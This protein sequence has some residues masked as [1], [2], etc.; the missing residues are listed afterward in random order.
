LQN[1]LVV[2]CCEQGKGGGHLSRCTTLVKD[3]RAA[4]KEA[5]LYLPGETNISALENLFNSAGFNKE[6]LDYKKSAEP[7]DLII[8]DRF[9]TPL[10]EIL[11]WKNLA[12]V[13]G[14]DEGGK[15]RDNFDFLIDMLI[16]EKLGNPRANIA[17]PALLFKNSTTNHTRTFGTHKHEPMRILVSFGQEDSA[18]LGIKVVQK[19]SKMNKNNDWEITLV[20]GELSN[21][22]E[23]ITMNNI[24][25]RDSIPNLAEHLGEY[26]LVITHYGL[27]A[28]EALFAGTYVLLAH[29]TPYHRK[30][31]NAA[32]FE[33]FTGKNFTQR[34]EQ[35]KK[36]QNLSSLC[37]CGSWLENKTLTDLINSFSPRVNR[38]CPVCGETSPNKS[39]ARFCDRTYRKCE[40]CGIIFM[41]RMNPPPI[42]YEK[43]YF[44]ESYKK[45]Y[46]KTYLEDFDNIKT[47]GKQRLKFINKNLTTENTEK[48][49]FSLLDIGCAYGPFL[50]AA[51]EEGFSPFGIDPAEDA[52]RYVQEKLNIPAIHGF[53]PLTDSSLRIEFSSTAPCSL[54]SATCSTF[55]ALFDA[56]TLW[57]VIEHFTDCAS[58]LSEIKKLLKLN[59]VLAFSTPSFSGISGRSNRK[60]FLSASPADHYTVW[61]PKMCKKA[62]SLAGFKVKKIVIAG[63]H[64]ERFPLLDKFAD[65]KKSFI[66]RLLLSISKIFGL[67]DTF[68]VYAVKGK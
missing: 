63:H 20:K 46:G 6:W 18:N 24:C 27:T 7:F 59:G 8:L 32:G 26:D 52:V 22:K 43:E 44:F 38:H 30:V 1:I 5:F 42:E 19:L 4:S 13:I 16:P 55:P 45:Q 2:P 39:T 12:P 17:S 40:K 57:Y 51:R 56:V 41:D 47:A 25:V 49:R 35:R 10:N 65:N 28:Y 64:P 14:I 9:Q 34:R 60:R 66:Y 62:L 68:E 23:Q 67:G 33:T 15:Y 31:A 50:A 48:K 3:L 61:A 29:P 21:Y 11:F 37:S 53:F 54:L 36:N 58:V